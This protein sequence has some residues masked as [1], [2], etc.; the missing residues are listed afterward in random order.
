MGNSLA[1]LGVGNGLGKAL[2]RLLLVAFPCCS[3]LWLAIGCFGLLWLKCAFRSSA[4]Q[5]LPHVGSFFAF[6]RNCSL[7]FS[8][9]YFTLNFDKFLLDFRRVLVGFGEAGRVEKTRFLAFLVVFFSK[10]YFR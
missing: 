7:F 1:N 2:G 10:P 3:L 9:P 5:V 6:F 4:D 8:F